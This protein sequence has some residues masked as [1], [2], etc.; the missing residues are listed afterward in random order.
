[1]STLDELAGELQIA[2]WGQ[3]DPQPEPMVEAPGADLFCYRCIHPLGERTTG[4]SVRA[5]EKIWLHYHQTCYE[6]AVDEWKA[7]DT[8]A[9]TLDG[10]DIDPW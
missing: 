3:W 1:M 10:D 7:R 2:F 8:V 6:E 9:I 4:A 5:D